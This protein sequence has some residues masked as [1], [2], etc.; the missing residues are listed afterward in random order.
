MVL[1]KKFIY[2]IV[3]EFPINGEILVSHLNGIVDNKSSPTL[4][5]STEKIQV[6]EENLR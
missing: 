6:S 1:G 2:T 4:L 3:L 5:G